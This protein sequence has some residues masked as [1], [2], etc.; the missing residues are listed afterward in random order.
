MSKRISNF[1]NGLPFYGYGRVRGFYEAS[2]GR[3]PYHLYTN[4]YKRKVLTVIYRAGY[5]NG[6]KLYHELNDNNS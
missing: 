2:T 1:L 4:S 6:I 5:R 3:P